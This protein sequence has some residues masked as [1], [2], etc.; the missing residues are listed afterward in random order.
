MKSIYIA[1]PYQGKG[2]NKLKVTDICRKIAE[3]GYL[4]I[5]P[6]HAMGFYDEAVN[7]EER[8][9]ALKLCRELVL[10]C[11]VVLLCGDWENSEGCM[12]EFEVALKNNIPAIGYK[13]KEIPRELLANV[14]RSY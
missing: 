4:P 2:E 7:P 5:S 14:L 10:K 12:M 1:H 11:D 6:I 9:Q 3:S 8:E 13:E